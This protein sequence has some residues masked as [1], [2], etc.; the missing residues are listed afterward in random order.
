VFGKTKKIGDDI[1]HMHFRQMAAAAA[2]EPIG[3]RCLVRAFSASS[4]W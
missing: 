3:R 4:N 1:G 2:E